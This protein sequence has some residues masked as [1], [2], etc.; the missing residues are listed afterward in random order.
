MKRI[1]T[2]DILADR[3]IFTEEQ[4][5]RIDEN[6]QKEALKVL[7]GGKRAG[8]GRKPKGEHPLIITVKV[9]DIELDFLNYARANGINLHNLM[10]PQT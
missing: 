2:D 6:A 3:T 5:K 8:A 1:T 9:S 7:H 10:N 4:A